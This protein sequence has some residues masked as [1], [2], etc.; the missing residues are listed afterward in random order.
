MKANEATSPTVL[1]LVSFW[2]G[3]DECPLLLLLLCGGG[4]SEGRSLPPSAYFSSSSSYDPHCGK[5][6]I[7]QRTVCRRA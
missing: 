2:S 5:K 1:V 4:L 7:G 3:F 6:G